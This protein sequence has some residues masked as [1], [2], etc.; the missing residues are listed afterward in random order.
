MVEQQTI[1]PAQGKG[2]VGGGQGRLD[3]KLRRGLDLPITGA[4][5][6]AIEDGPAIT[7]CALIG[8]DYLGLKPRMQV[9]EGDRVRLGQPLFADRRFEDV[10]YTAPAGGRVR[11]VNRGPRRVLESVVI[12]IDEQDEPIAF[13]RYQAE[14]LEGLEAEDA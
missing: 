4:P 11:A 9:A 14:E 7:S 6:Q 8:A 1:Q 12:D 5:D 10:V 13:S 3:F 2:A